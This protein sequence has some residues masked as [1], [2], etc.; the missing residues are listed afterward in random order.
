MLNKQ[1]HINLSPDDKE[2]IEQMIVVNKEDELQELEV[3]FKKINYPNYLRIVEHYI[4][5][6]DE[7]NISSFNSLDIIVTLT[8]GNNYRVSLMDEILIDSFINTYHKSS[9]ADIQ[10]YILSLVPSNKI[11]IIFKNRET[12]T[13]LFIED[14]NMVFKLTQ[15]QPVGKNKPEFIGTEKI[16]YRYKERVSFILNKNFRLDATVVKQSTKLSILANSDSVYE[17]ELETINRK[18]TYAIFLDQIIEV[19]KIIQN[20]EVL[21]GKKEANHVI[22]SYMNI[23]G[24]RTTITSPVERKVI[25]VEGQHIV[26]FIPNK[27][28]TTDKVDGERYFLISLATGIYLLSLNMTVKKTVYITDKKEYH[29]MI[30]DGELIRD[31]DDNTALLIIDAVYVNNIDFR[32]DPKFNLKHRLTV[33]YDVIDKCFNNIIPFPDYMDHN[34]DLDLNK[35]KTFYTK[36]LKTYW[37]TFNKTL[38]K[39]SNLFI[40]RKLYFIPYGI[41]L[42]EIF[43]YADM[44]WKLYVYDGLT[45][46]KL[47]GMIYTPLNSSYLIKN[48]PD[49]FDTIPQDYKWKPPNLNSIDFFIR[50]E[51]DKSTNEDAI[52]FD[53]SIKNSGNPYK[54]CKLFVHSRRDKEIPIPFLVNKIEQRSFIYIEDGVALDIEGKIIEDNTVV[55]FAFDMT[56]NDIDN[57]FKWMPLRTRYDKTESVMKYGTK[58]GNHV[59]IAIRIWK[60]IINPIT[61]ENIFALSNPNTYQIEMDKIASITELTTPVYYQK[62]S[63]TVPGMT[64]FHNWIKSNMIMTY[65][66]NKSSLLDIGMGRG[67]DLLKIINANV[68]TCVG[69]D[70]DNN[71]LYVINDSAF[72]R[73]K[74]FQKTMKNITNMH[75][76]NANA[77]GL[78]NTKSQMGIIPNMTNSNKNMIDTLLSGNKKY[79]VINCQFSIHYYLSDPISWSNFCQNI[80]DHLAD[81]GYMLITCFDGKLIHNKLKGNKSIVI[82][83][84]NNNGVKSTFCEIVKMYT[85][86]A[87]VGLG[88][89]IDVYNS[90]VNI[91]GQ[92]YSEYLVDPEFL[93]KSFNE[94]CGMELVETDLFYNIFNLY[95]TYFTI[96]MIPN[97]MDYLVGDSK[98]NHE[99]IMKYYMTLDPKNKSQFLSEDVD[100]NLAAFDM[101]SLNRYY[102]FKKKSNKINLTEPARIVNVNHKIN[103]GKVMI[104]YFDKNNIYIDPINKNNINEIYHS[105]LESPKQKPNVYLIRHSIIG[106]DILHQNK[107]ELAR[108]KEGTSPYVLLIYKSPENKF[109]QI[110][111]TNGDIKYNFFDSKKIIDDLDILIEITDKINN[112]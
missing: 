82:G 51:K 108:I 18:I 101:S 17:I 55:E 78:F 107:I 100:A 38:T 37:G 11:E 91:P 81:N 71:G 33:V 57:S 98:T 86:S 89:G 95:K 70:M 36:E 12:G 74:N 72:K 103:L 46:Y 61:E 50:F 32:D 111:H 15:E 41:D 48:K 105:V 60:T 79:D 93:E 34:K 112:D 97:K 83:Q 84:T 28:C 94:K 75:F 59:S 52:F 31:A 26:K 45:P 14:F 109:H 104:P 54:V 2:I 27:Y 3:S 44:I 88:L 96:P 99:K 20:A 90:T 39:S 77:K 19:L 9:H 40:T 8:S 67:G 10:K 73:Y 106:D 58:Y 80:N 30:L 66:F 16:L 110:Y 22:H 76:I 63:V 13:R 4:N 68:K 21:L 42:Y 6:I 64:A 69:V 85:D 87:P 65:A 62:K 5:N 7:K 25:S 23:L 92:Y 35:I 102:V 47:D 1:T 53:E 49:D 56:Q 24:I 29:N 43:M